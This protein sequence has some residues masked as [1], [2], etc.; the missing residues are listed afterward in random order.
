M[1]L[2]KRKLSW[3]YHNII[4]IIRETKICHPNINESMSRYLYYLSSFTN[5]ISQILVMLFSCIKQHEIK[6]FCERDAYN[7]SNQNAK[8]HLSFEKVICFVVFVSISIKDEN[9]IIHKLRISNRSVYKKLLQ[10]QG[11]LFKD[12]SDDVKSHLSKTPFKSKPDTY[13][14]MQ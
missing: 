13:F 4:C 5:E 9:N 2:Y 11:E 7:G 14:R 10:L 12:I 1:Y 3:L 6:L 8:K